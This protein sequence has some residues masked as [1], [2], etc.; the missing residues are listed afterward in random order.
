MA[1]VGSTPADRIMCVARHVWNSAL[2]N[3]NVT[4]LADQVGATSLLGMPMEL[5]LA[6]ELDAAGVRGAAGRDA[7]RAILLC[8]AGFL[9][10][11]FRSDS[12]APGP[13]SREPRHTE[14][15]VLWA[16][17]IDTGIDPTTLDALRRPPDLEALFDIT[18]R[19]VIDTFV[20]HDDLS[21]RD[22]P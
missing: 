16:E 1:I 6:R 17:I 18:V 22:N 12:T 8:V 11:G 7:L 3:R 2:T 13:T 10:A 5:A 9:V 15:H 4:A 21:R 14:P 20:P 19:A